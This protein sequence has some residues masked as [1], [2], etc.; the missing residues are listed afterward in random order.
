MSSV[1]VVTIAALDLRRRP[2]HRSELRSQLL[3][4]EL[5]DER[6]AARR[7][8]WSRVENR[9]DGY[10]GWARTWG[11]RALASAEAREWESIARWRVASSWRK[12]SLRAAW[13]ANWK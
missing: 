8:R 12:S 7:G 6:A 9:V 5:V 2:D 10:R 3:L 13:A 1:A 11:L 4:G